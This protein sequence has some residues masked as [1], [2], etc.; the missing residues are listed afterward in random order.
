[1]EAKKTQ[2]ADLEGKKGLFILLGLII[3]LS[4]MIIIFEWSSKDVSQA[5]LSDNR[6]IVEEEEM[7]LPEEQQPEPE[8]VVAQPIMSDELNIVDENV[9]I[10][11]D[12]NFTSEDDK[13][14]AV[15]AV[16]YVQKAVVVEQEV[17]EEVPFALVED[18]PKFQGG[19]ANTF[20]KWV[21][22]K[23]TYPETPRDNGVQGKVMLRFTVDKD[24]YVKNVVVTKKVDP[25][26]DKEAVRVV[27]SSP[28]WTPGKQR[29]KNVAVIYDFP[30]NFQ[31]Q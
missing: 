25:D 4:A 14:F 29:T 22:G 19:D 18:K 11:T 21:M 13:K 10:N 30:V 5:V 17:E 7:P 27:S 28:R 8:Q 1:M 23:I 6:E 12:L 9:D 20:Q 16:D 31:L 3:S 15:T 2:K 26:L 24:G